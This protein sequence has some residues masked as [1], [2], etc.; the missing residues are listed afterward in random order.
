MLV[1]A[2]APVPPRTP[3]ASGFS[4]G[5]RTQ[6]AVD[7]GPTPE[8][9]DPSDV[10]EESDRDEVQEVWVN[11]LGGRLCKLTLAD[12]SRASSLKQ[13]IEV[14][15]G[16]PVDLQRLIAGTTELQDGD[17]VPRNVIGEGP[18]EVM[19]LRRT[20]EEAE[21]LTKVGHSWTQFL[22]A[23]R[24]IRADYEVTLAAVA[25]KGSL[26]H[27]ASQELRADRRVVLSAVRNDGNALQYAS[28]ALRDDRDIVLE[29]VQADGRALGY[30]GPAARSD[31]EVVAA[32]VRSQPCALQYADEPL[33]NDRDLALMAVRI[34]GNALRYA[35]R[36]ARKDVEVAVTA[37]QSSQKA[38]R[39]TMKE[40]R[41]HPDVMAAMGLD[42]EE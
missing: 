42:P 14:S 18:V 24:E 40:V 25:Q 22:G 11:S 1:G 10:G 17:I 23:P 30:A 5:R 9:S 15:T 20:E 6:K 21:W 13:A 3:R 34:D 7:K 38:F 41:L 16:T 19:L 39:Y 8:T 27:Y 37:I 33:R 29:A 2:C 4:S 28:E 31:L 35:G 26:L 36:H 32:A 12:G